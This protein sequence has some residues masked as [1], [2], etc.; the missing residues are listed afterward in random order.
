MSDTI[1]TSALIAMLKAAR[2]GPG[3]RVLDVAT[4]AG[5][6]AGAAA[7]MGAMPTGLDFAQAQVELARQVHPEVE[8]RQGDA[9]DLPFESGTFDAVVMGFGMT[10]LPDPEKAALEARRV[11]R[12]GGA[13]ACTVWAPP[14]PGEGFG[15]VLSAIDEH[16]GPDPKLPAAPPYFRFADECEVEGI[17]ASAGFAGISTDVIPQFWRHTTPDESFDAFNKGAVR[18]TAMLRSQPESVRETVRRQVREEVTKLKSGGEYVVPVPAAL[19]VGF[20]RS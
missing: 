3:S 18:A 6:V 1:P 7:D 20:K 2:V 19:S 5:Y 16:G 12:S 8:F 11:L 13:F 14:S 4:G 10:H 17:L 9:Q 15:I